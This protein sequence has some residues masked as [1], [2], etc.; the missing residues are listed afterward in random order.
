MVSPK[1]SRIAVVGTDSFRG[2]EIKNTLEKGRLAAVD[3]DFFDVDVDEEFSKLTQ[4]CGEAR[5][6]QRLT[7]ESLGEEDLVFLAAD[8]D[9]NIAF[10]NQAKE[11]KYLAIDL[12]ESFN[13]IKDIPLVVAGVNA[14]LIH[15][16]KSAIIANPHPVSIILSHIIRSLD[17]RF[18]LKRIVS[19]VLQPA[20]AM[21]ESGIQELANQSASLLSSSPLSKKVFKAQAAFNLLSQIESLNEDG[22]SPQ[23]KQVI[24]EIK[25]IFKNEDLPLS[26]SFIQTPVFH[27]YSIMS[28][29]ELK[30]KATLKN[31]KDL[32]NE[33]SYFKFLSPS[34]SCPVS[35]ISVAGKD[36]I[37]IGQV[38]KDRSFPNSFWVWAVADNL[39]RGSAL[40]AY[41]IAKEALTKHPDKK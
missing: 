23:E 35:S 39:T 17:R 21:E 34:K 6:I 10:G 13:Q 32:F 19:S 26:L 16:T 33:N 37:F 29:F 3:V 4:F 14:D 24:S 27:T 15:R 7:P 18:G 31:I 38:K 22:F 30:A 36:E 40:N 25:R 12:N 2:K 11:K 28:F 5:A 8:K 1:R 9:T 41:A 20:S